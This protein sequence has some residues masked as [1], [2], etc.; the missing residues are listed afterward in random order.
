MSLLDR[1]FASPQNITTVDPHV[2]SVIPQ[3]FKKIDHGFKHEWDTIA[4]HYLSFIRLLYTQFTKL[5]L[6]VIHIDQ[7][8]SINTWYKGIFLSPAFPNIII[9]SLLGDT[10]PSQQGFLNECEPLISH[11]NIR[12]V[13]S[14]DMKYLI[15]FDVPLRL[16]YPIIDAFF[17]N[18]NMYMEYPERVVP[19]P[20]KTQRRKEI[21]YYPS[22][23]YND[24]FRMTY[25]IYVKYLKAM[26]Y[27]TF[28]IKNISTIDIATMETI[29]K[30]LR[31]EYEHK[32]IIK[33]ELDEIIKFFKRVKIF[34]Q[35]VEYR[36]HRNTFN[37]G[38]IHF[39]IR[40]QYIDIR[41][42]KILKYHDND[43]LQ[44]FLEHTNTFKYFTKRR[45]ERYEE[46]IRKQMMIK[47]GK[48]KLK[49]EPIHFKEEQ[50]VY[51][52][53]QWDNSF[54]VIRSGDENI[55]RQLR[56]IVSTFIEYNI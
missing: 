25:S 22:P 28:D 44:W 12:L 55:D 49:P 11:Y 42:Y 3:I 15:L 27:K 48:L 8:I 41:I 14:D 19:K 20:S 26:A 18:N 17:R 23:F 1:F 9:L 52:H 45:I 13:K 39:W 47:V 5:E 21:K 32:I 16:Y 37:Y 6:G 54:P 30:S 40:L 36:F 29:S 35:I 51:Y 24:V 46:S 56:S 53:S 31:Y 2:S 34:N 4:T 10:A 33:S 43:T 50:P 38:K 7:I